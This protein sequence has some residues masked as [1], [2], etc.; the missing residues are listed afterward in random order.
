M[1]YLAHLQK[2][3]PTS[4]MAS[5]VTNDV[6]I[7]FP[8]TSL[9]DNDTFVKRLTTFINT[10]YIEGEAEFWKGGRIDRCQPPEVRDLIISGELAIA[11]PQQS[12]SP[13]SSFHD[14]SDIAGCIK[15]H[16]VDEKTAT[17]GILTSAQAY[18]GK[19]IGRQLVQFAEAWAREHGA[20]KMQMELLFANGWYHPLKTRLAEWYERAGYQLARSINMVDMYP[21]LVELLEQPSDLRVYQKALL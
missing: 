11:W 8:A 20:V 13:S 12:A 2:S 21:D 10:V 17:F 14:G 5:T 1:L 15:V 16:M 7:S 9:G 18:R 19:G 6:H 3:F 4:T